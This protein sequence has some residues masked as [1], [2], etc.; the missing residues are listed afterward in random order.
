MVCDFR[1][2][3]HNQLASKHIEKV[4]RDHKYNMTAAARYLN[5]SRPTLYRLIKKHK[6]ELD[7]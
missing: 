4:I 3:D 2:V 6:L 1:S 7:S 5:I